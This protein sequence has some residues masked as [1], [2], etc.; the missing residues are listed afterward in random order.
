MSSTHTTPPSSPTRL[1]QLL[2]LLALVLATVLASAYGLCT[3]D[4]AFISFRYA[5]NLWEG[6]G[7]VFNSGE[8]VE[9]ITNLLWTLFFVPAFAL[10]IDP[11]LFSIIL[12]LLSLGSLIMASIQLGRIFSISSLPIALLIAIDGSVLLESMEGL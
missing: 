3:Q 4:D 9:G 2:I 1:E 12:G 11:V 10:N 5:Q 7:L 8:K 6:H